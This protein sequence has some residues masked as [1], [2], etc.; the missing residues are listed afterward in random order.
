MAQQQTAIWRSELFMLRRAEIFNLRFVLM[1][2]NKRRSKKK[3]ETGIVVWN[4]HFAAF[5]VLIFLYYYFVLF[6]WTKIINFFI[7]YFAILKICVLFMLIVIFGALVRERMCMCACQRWL[8]VHV[9]VQAPE[10]H[11]Q[12]SSYIQINSYFCSEMKNIR[13]QPVLLSVLLVAIISKVKEQ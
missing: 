2:A 13:D 4:S 1:G 5:V 12:Y 10:E 8:H 6:I 7:A 9:C 3:L 11:W